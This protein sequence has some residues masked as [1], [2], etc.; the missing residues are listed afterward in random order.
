[1]THHRVMQTSL[2]QTRL[3]EAP[4]EGFNEWLSVSVPGRVIVT[5]QRVLYGRPGYVTG[6]TRT[7]L[8]EKFPVNSVF[9]RLV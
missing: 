6:R 9:G 7:V 4:I 2:V 8:K 3:P 5:P 1:M